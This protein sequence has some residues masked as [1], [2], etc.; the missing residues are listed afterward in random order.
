[1]KKVFKAILT[2]IFIGLVIYVIYRNIALRKIPSENLIKDEATSSLY[3][4]ILPNSSNTIWAN[5]YFS[6]D[7][8]SQKDIPT[9]M[10]Y[11]I[12]FKK[13]GSSEK[14]ISSDKFKE[15]Y[16]ALFGPNTYKPV[17]T[18]TGGCNTYTY[19]DNTKIYSK[20]TNIPCPSTKVYILSKIVDAEY[21]DKNMEITVVIAYIDNE[22]KT[23]YKEC[24]EDMSSCSSV[25][26]NNFTEFDEANLEQVKDKLHKYK[27]TYNNIN[28]EYYFS[29][30]RKIS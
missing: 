22:T 10:T 24:N 13:I 12:A 17:S 25:I 3:H 20:T 6:H 27:F 23:V 30:V 29:S 16:E 26:K 8:V 1:M 28:D 19:D 9:D 5:Y 18:F 14:Q 4:D 11:N 2:I 21:T 7:N 15:S